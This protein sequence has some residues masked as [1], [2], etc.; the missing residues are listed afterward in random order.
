MRYELDVNVCV[1]YCSEFLKHCLQYPFHI[2]DTVLH[3]SVLS[4][5]VWWPC[6]CNIM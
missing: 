2:G 6:K 5:C 3:V 4:Y 1:F